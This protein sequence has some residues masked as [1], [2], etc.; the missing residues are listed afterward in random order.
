MRQVVKKLRRQKLR[1]MCQSRHCLN[2]LTPVFFLLFLLTSCRDVPVVEV[3]QQKGD[4][5]KENMINANRYIS[6][7][8]EAQ[9]DAYVQ[10][11]GWEMQRLLGG[12]RVMEV[13]SG[14]AKDESGKID[15]EDVVAIRYSVEAIS[16][17]VIYGNVEDTL[18]VG[19]LQPTR[20]LDA[21]LRTLTPGS[22]AVVILPSE[23]AYGVVGDGDRI[24]S[25][26]RMIL[27]YKIHN[28]KKI[29]NNTSHK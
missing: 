12:A 6:Q 7:G 25:G 29:N 5:L 20:G 15:Y 9:I 8:E 26:S 21:A 11:R 18:T 3:G 10:R 17:E 19:R 14:K 1:Q 24:A 22:Q 23:Q 28:I 13:E 2:Y 27:I 4:T 16:G